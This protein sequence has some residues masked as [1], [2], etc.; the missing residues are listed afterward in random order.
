MFA[1]YIHIPYCLHKCGY[2]DFN[3]FAVDSPE[4]EP[5]LNALFREM[6]H[7]AKTDA[8]VISTIFL[9]GGTPTILP[10]HF[11]EQLLEKCHRL[12]KIP[13]DCE[14][15]IEANPATIRAGY[16][17]QIRAA[18]Y[19][20]ISIG[21][22]SFHDHE[23]KQLDRVHSAEEVYHTVN[24]AREAGFDNLSLDL[25]FALPGQTM[26]EWEGNLSQA[27][28]LRP[29]HISTYNLTI[30]SG[31]AFY[32][33]QSRGKLVMPLEDFQLRLY[34]KTI[35]I[36][37]A[38]GYHHYEISNFCK[39]GK[40]SRH[41]INYWENGEYLGLGAGAS[42]FLDGVRFKNQDIPSKYIQ[43]ILK[44]GSAAVSSE[45][46]ALPTAMGETLMMGL[47]LLKGMNIHQFE[48]R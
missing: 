29:E 2:C 32:K 25:M 35:K 10:A 31:T 12:F 19:N 45:Q 11:L 40:E 30:E 34:K 46:L 44:D 27:I 13:S 6:E 26:E 8:P 3:S 38:A 22:Q 47:R 20:R 33:S 39:P 24:R 23:L 36:L 18:G 28:A 42:S 7:Y 43:Q 41:N 14:I 15:T 5:Y 17:Q 1:L 37:K 9:G 48:S 4:A 21:V 16:L